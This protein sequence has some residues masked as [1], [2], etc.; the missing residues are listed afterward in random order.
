MVITKAG[1]SNSHLERRG[2]TGPSA[3]KLAL[4]GDALKLPL[5]RLETFACRT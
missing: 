5:M 1:Q 3:V 2:R 4:T